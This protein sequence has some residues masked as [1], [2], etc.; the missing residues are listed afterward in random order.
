VTDLGATPFVDP[1]S[2]EISVSKPGLR[3]VQNTDR[4]ETVSFREILDP[5]EVVEVLR[6]RHRIY[7][8]QQ[9]YGPA[10]ALRLDLTSHDS[11]S[12]VFGVFRGEKLVGS[13][14]LVLRKQ[15]PLAAMFRA[16][17]A[18]AESSPEEVSTRLP[19]EEAFDVRASIGSQG[20][21]ID[22]ELGRFALD[23]G[24][25]PVHLAPRVVIASLA[26]AH[27]AGCRLYLYSCSISI[28]KAYARV[29][30]PR[31]ILSEHADTGIAS[32]HFIFPKPT[33]AAVAAVEDSPFSGTIDSYASQLRNR[34]PIDLSASIHPL[35]AAG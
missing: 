9:Q 19:S 26:A 1:R 2:E 34:Q 23:S 21:L 4:T 30:K 5:T 20:E 32:D 10:R 11:R 6:L 35:Q 15:Q 25:I 18:V 17:R 31:Y 14:R 33:L 27:Q 29:T 28:A 13:V 22:G 16:L 8:E 12:R 7:F 3:S 24:A